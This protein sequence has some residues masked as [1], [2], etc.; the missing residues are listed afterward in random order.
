MSSYLKVKFTFIVIWMNLQLIVDYIVIYYIP[1]L[2][3]IMKRS[4]IFCLVSYHM[5]ENWKF[6]IIFFVVLC[7]LYSKSSLNNTPTLKLINKRVNLSFYIRANR[8][9]M[10]FYFA[11]ALIRW[12]E[13]QCLR[14]N[15]LANSVPFI[16]KFVLKWV[17]TLTRIHN[18]ILLNHGN[19]S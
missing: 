13:N 4:W 2:M 15:N 6:R 12:Y 9:Y 10:L 14:I 17:Y 8:F 19:I 3:I 11:C 7:K 1:I 18:I 16:F 5:I